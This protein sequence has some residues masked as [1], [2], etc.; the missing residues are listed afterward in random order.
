MQTPQMLRNRFKGKPEITEDERILDEA[1]KRVKTTKDA[2][3]KIKPSDPPEQ[4]EQKRNEF[5]QAER[6]LT[7]L[8]Q[9]QE[10]AREAARAAAELQKRG[11]VQVNSKQFVTALYESSKEANS[12][13]MQKF[14]STL[15]SK[16]NLS[17][18]VLSGG[19]RRRRHNHKKSI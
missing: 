12:D 5:N 10:Q 1:Q 9:E 17:D 18:L 16:L 19:S 6:D 3:N 4:Q 8:M 7:A 14:Y 2:L 13:W 15:K 11:E